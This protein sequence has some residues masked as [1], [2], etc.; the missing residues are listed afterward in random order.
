MFKFSYANQD[1]TVCVLGVINDP[2]KYYD[3][4]QCQYV[5]ASA[6]IDIIGLIIVAAYYGA[7]AFK[8]RSIMPSWAV[9]CLLTKLFEF[10]PVFFS[11]FFYRI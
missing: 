8:D 7:L 1:Y 9:S 5:L 2:M 3:L 11:F 10:C 4:T 6:A